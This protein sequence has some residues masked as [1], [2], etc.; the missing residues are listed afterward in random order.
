KDF[1]EWMKWIKADDETLP[2]F[3]DRLIFSKNN[4]MTFLTSAKFKDGDNIVYSKHNDRPMF[5]MKDNGFVSIYQ[6]NPSSIKSALQ[7]YM[8]MN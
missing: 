3:R 6:N 1:V 2:E 5:E 7:A 4:K 8:A